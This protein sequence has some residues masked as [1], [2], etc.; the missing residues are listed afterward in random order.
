[1]SIEY[2][3]TGISTE[4]EVDLLI[5]RFGT[6][7]EGELV[8]YR[9]IALVAKT[10][11]MTERFRTVLDAWRR[12]LERAHNVV[13]AAR[14]GQGIV[15]LPPDGRIYYAQSNI[16]SAARKIRKSARRAELTD[17]HRLSPDLQRSRDAILGVAATMRLAARTAPKKLI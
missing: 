2:I 17:V 3:K 4:P 13:T 5:K 8:P 6:L 16:Q 10:P 15:A 7:K 12:R 11:I 1:M 14:P 9:E